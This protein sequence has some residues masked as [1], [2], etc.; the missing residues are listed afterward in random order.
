[1][2]EFPVDPM[3]SKAIIASETYKVR[4]AHHAS[5]QAR[6]E[7]MAVTDDYPCSLRP[8]Q[9]TAEVLTVVSMLSIGA[10]VFYRPKDKAVRALVGRPRP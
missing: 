5:M 6:E 1:M 8:P 10:S 4:L 3:M 2:A 9:C 7:D